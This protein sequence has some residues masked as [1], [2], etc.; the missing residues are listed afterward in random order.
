MPDAFA[1]FRSVQPRSLRN[2]L[3]RVPSRSNT[4][5]ASVSM[6]GNIM[7]TKFCCQQDSAAY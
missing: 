5:M 1:N 4:R 3:T 2:A 6:T 7:L